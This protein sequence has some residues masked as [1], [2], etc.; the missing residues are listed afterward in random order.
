[1][2]VKLSEIIQALHQDDDMRKL[3]GD[4]VA[5]GEEAGGGATES[6]VSEQIGSSIEDEKAKI[7]TKLMEL[8]GQQVAAESAGKATE[9]LN[10]VQ[11]APAG[12][13]IQPPGDTEGESS[14]TEVAEVLASVLGG[15]QPEQRKIACKAVITKI[16]QLNVLAMD[17]LKDVKTAEARFNE[18]DAAGRIMARAYHD[19]CTKIA[20]SLK[21]DAAAP[22]AEKVAAEKDAAEAPADD[23]SAD[24]VTLLKELI[25]K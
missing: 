5:E 14:A 20:A 9:Q 15:M 19:E 4:K 12:E 7:Q 24:E 11:G 2:G 13:R 6:P 16:A 17:D 25:A 10:A 23:L 18:Y 3:A 8:A 1:M 21:K 22:A